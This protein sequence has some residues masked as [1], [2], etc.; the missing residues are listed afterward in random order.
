M[1]RRLPAGLLNSFKTFVFHDRLEACPT[2]GD[3]MQKPPGCRP[4]KNRLLP[5]LSGFP[6]GAGAPTVGDRGGEAVSAADY[7][8][9]GYVTEFKY[10]AMM[11]SKSVLDDSDTFGAALERSVLEADPRWQD[12]LVRRLAP[13]EDK[14]AKVK[15][16][17]TNSPDKP[18]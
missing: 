18:D 2:D 14:L 12:E 16:T 6:A 5:R 1:E 4:K 13:L 3:A 7:L 11:Q 10:E 15:E 9:D 17:L 8:R